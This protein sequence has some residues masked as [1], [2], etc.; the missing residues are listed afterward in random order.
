MW[1]DV[2]AGRF[3]GESDYDVCILSFLL[4]RVAEW[5]S[6]SIYMFLHIVRENS[7]HTQ[8]RCGDGV[9]VSVC[10]CVCVQRNLGS[11]SPPPAGKPPLRHGADGGVTDIHTHTCART[12][13]HTHMT[14]SIAP[15][16]ILVHL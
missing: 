10:V 3:V 14:I 4:S 5:V 11:K 7:L 6:T 15:E 8:T 16:Y 12:H 9:G 13:T 2:G 1:G